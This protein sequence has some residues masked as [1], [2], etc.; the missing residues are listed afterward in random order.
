M[1]DMN[2]PN[3][4]GVVADTR[5]PAE[6]EFDIKHTE[7]FTSS[8]PSYAASKA[9]ASKYV[10]A[11]P[12]DNQQ[13]T[14]SCVAHG[15]VLALGIFLFLQGI[16]GDVFVALSSMF[17]YRNRINYPSEGMVPSSADTQI[18]D[19]GAPPYADIPTP[20]TEVE[21]NA[22]PV[23]DAATTKAAQQFAGIKWVTLVDPT[24]IDTMAFVS[25]SLG[26]PLNI[27]IYAT[28]EEWSQSVVEIMTP[29][30]EQGSPEAAVSHCITVLPQSAYEVNGEKFVIIQDSA[31]FGGIAFRSVSAAFIK[32]RT[33]ECAYPI[34]IDNTPIITKPKHTFAADLTIGS[35]GP[36]VLALQQILQYMGYLP[37]VVNGKVFAPT[38]YYGGMTKTA[39]LA[40]QNEYA[41][42]ILTPSGL[43]AGTGYFGT[44]TRNFINGLFSN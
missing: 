34:S 8:A 3:N 32:A 16:T 25:N 42:E 1:T 28:I 27:L 41:A 29:G 10:G 17:V 31:L 36:D 40:L 12:I 11:F 24:D 30:L 18:E 26:L 5:T 6:K 39:V 21:A 22:L 4:C 33:Y 2:V 9:A 14:S 44:S 15:K 23:P 43:T 38:D 37:N 19:A 35:T 7:L 20:A 13:G